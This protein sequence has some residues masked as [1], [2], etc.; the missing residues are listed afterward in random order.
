MTNAIF[1]IYVTLRRTIPQNV[2]VTMGE[3]LDPH[4]TQFRPTA[5]PHY[6]VHTRYAA[7]L[8]ALARKSTTTMKAYYY[9]LTLTF[10]L[11]L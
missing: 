8:A 5:L 4:F 2:S 7:R 1:C 10:Y 3:G 11:D 9:S 6:H